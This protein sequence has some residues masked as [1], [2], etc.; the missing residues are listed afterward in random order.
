MPVRD[1]WVLLSRYLR[2]QLG[3][4]IGVG[5]LLFLQIGL[6]LINPQIMRRFID[7]A[8]SG[9]PLATLV[10]I[11][12]IFLVIALLTQIVSVLAAYAGERVGWTATNQLRADLTRHCLGLDMSFHNQHT[13]GEMIERIDGDAKALGRFFSTFVITV[14]GNV[15]MLVGIMALLFREDWR[16]GLTLAAIA[17]VWLGVL[18]RLRNLTVIHH[19]E[20]RE[21]STKV[22]GF[23]EES[24]SG[25]EDVG[26]NGARPW[27][28]NR[29]EDLMRTWFKKDLK[30][31]VMTSVLVNTTSFMFALA[32]AASLAVGAYLLLNNVITLGAVFLIFHY[33]SMLRGPVQ[34]LAMRLDEIQMATA[35]IIRIGE[36]FHTKPKVL[37]GKG[38]VLPDGPLSVS[39]DNVSF[40]YGGDSVLKD[41]SFELK[42][43]AV[44]GLLGRTGSGKTTLTRLLFRLYDPGLGTVMVN[45][46]DVRQTAVSD[47]RRRVGLVTQDVR[48]FHG[49]VRDNLSLFDTT[50]PDERLL[51]VVGLL[52][53]ADW[54]KGLPNGLDTMLQPEGGGLSS[55]Q[56]QLL[57]FTRVFLGNPGVVV[58]DEAL[59]RIDPHTERTIQ[60]AIDRLA[61]GRTLLIVA[62]R[63][64]T[65]DRMDEVMILDKGEI[66]EH[67]NRSEL[68]RNP[69]S[70][71]CQL[72]KA[73][74]E[75]VLT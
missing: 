46:T 15:V 25:T 1:Y 75:D 28:L 4:V 58:L 64:A 47:L 3:I 54:Y 45:G 49:S 68:A 39:F 42:P 51:E 22:F 57:A 67:G 36:L 72:L 16:V 9:S 14:L 7:D 8:Q 71:F 27:L 37:D 65:V 48:L 61:E 34:G 12:V 59:S 40:S 38:L 56:A 52:G 44:L 24:V 50:V 19:K 2:A 35:S 74:M 30:A 18:S 23:L 69:S 66:V 26:A 63:F 31:S 29:F 20:N 53:L 10:R 73:G 60:Q 55:G 33:T 62:H 11:A 70:R 43:G 13:P 5:T 6:Q 32:N 17:A 41:I 21:A